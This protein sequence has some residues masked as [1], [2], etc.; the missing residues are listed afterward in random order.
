MRYLVNAVDRFLQ[1]NRLEPKEVLGGLLVFAFLFASI[2]L[3][4][5]LLTRWGDRRVTGK[6]LLFSLLL[7]FAVLLGVVAVPH[8]PS[9]PGGGPDDPDGHEDQHRVVIHSVID[10]PQR[11]SKDGKV[12]GNDTP[13]WD[14]LPAPKIG[15]LMGPEPNNIATIAPKDVKRT[16]ES[17]EPLALKVPDLASL[18]E[19]QQSPPSPVRPEAGPLERA[20]KTAAIEIPKSGPTPK[21]QPR[22]P[23]LPK[24]E[25]TASSSADTSV[26]RQAVD[27]GSGKRALDDGLSP[28]AA[29][30]P[31]TSAPQV[32]APTP[33]VPQ[34]PGVASNSDGPLHGKP[35]PAPAT[36]ASPESS[37]SQKP[38]KGAAGPLV[39]DPV[40]AKISEGRWM[41]NVDRLRTNDTG[42]SA[43]SS[44]VPMN[45]SATGHYQSTD[46][47]PPAPEIQNSGT[48]PLL[49]RRNAG[50]APTYRLRK[51]SARKANARQFGGN[52]QSER[53]VEASLH[54]LA[55]V[56]NRNG[57][58]DAKAFGAG[59]VKVD[60]NG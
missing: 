16:D 42:D 21:P 15:K 31:L 60:E 32:P 13:V 53:A 5:M 40:N 46:S 58:W 41:A 48:T 8:P 36:M 57:S 51:L 55:S 44:T 1:G 30:L 43:A 7:H 35:Q 45:P 4:T 9:V 22:V 33:T 10:Q 52:D 39:R 24:R 17:P 29:K 50:I 38:A 2:H 14:R 26:K 54:W 23:T 37:P 11:E 25:L 56:Q 18:P 49:V 59:Q 12:Q 19:N 47:T 34:S 20:A 28:Q 6:A 3:V 27:A